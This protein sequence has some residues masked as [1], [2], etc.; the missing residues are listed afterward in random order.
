MTQIYTET[1]GCCRKSPLPN[2]FILIFTVLQ[3][4]HNPQQK[5]VE[6]FIIMA[7]NLLKATTVCSSCES[8]ALFTEKELPCY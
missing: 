8:A 2:V 6:P 5:G 4:C 1:V 7:L 3:T